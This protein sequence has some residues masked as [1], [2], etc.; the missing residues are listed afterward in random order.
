[1]MKCFFFLLFCD[2]YALA[3]TTLDLDKPEHILHVWRF[4]YL[5]PMLQVLT[6]NLHKR[7]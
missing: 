7:S 3:L 6:I 5:K 4:A 2:T 1:M